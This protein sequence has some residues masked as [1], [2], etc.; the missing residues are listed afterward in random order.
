[1]AAWPDCTD[2]SLLA[3]YVVPDLELYAP[4]LTPSAQILSPEPIDLSSGAYLYDHE[5]VAVGRGGFPFILALQRS[6]SSNNRYVVGPMGLGWAHNLAITATKNS[7]G[8]KGLGEDS[9]IAGAAAIA[10]AYVAQDLF[11]DTTAPLSKR[12]IATL[13]QRRPA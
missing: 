1:M 13:V 10:A 5:D 7:D 2:G 3:Q 9:P 8:L 6:Y 4:L 11:S 12:M